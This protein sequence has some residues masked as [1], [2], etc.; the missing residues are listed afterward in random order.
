MNDLNEL[1][2]QMPVDISKQ[3]FRLDD[4][5]LKLFLNWLNA[6][7]SKVQSALAPVQTLIQMDGVLLR[8]GDFEER[9]RFGLKTWFESL[10]MQG[11]LWE[12]RLVLDEHRLKMILNTEAG[13]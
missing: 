12:Y 1:L 7:N 5:R 8:Q 2:D 13:K 10:P 6:H 11:L 9:F 4:V 3:A